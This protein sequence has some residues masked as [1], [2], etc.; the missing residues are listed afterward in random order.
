MLWSVVTLYSAV[1]HAFY[2]WALFFD[3]RTRYIDNETTPYRLNLKPDEWL[4]LLDVLYFISVL[5]LG[6]AIFCAILSQIEVPL[7]L[8]RVVLLWLSIHFASGVFTAVWHYS[9]H[10][11]WK[12]IRVPI[13]LNGVGYLLSFVALLLSFLVDNT[14]LPPASIPQNEQKEEP[15]NKKTQ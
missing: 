8:K 1:I 4:L 5:Y 14:P 15:E 13:A 6:V 12:Y 9:R 3:A 2:A 10:V 7:K 11:Y